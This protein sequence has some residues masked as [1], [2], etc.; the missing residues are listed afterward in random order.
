MS[1][2]ETREKL[3]LVSIDGLHPG[4]LDLDRRGQSGGAPDNWLMPNVREFCEHALRYPE[5]RT[6]LPAATDMNHLNAVAGTSLAQTGVIGVWAQPT[7]WD[8]RGRAVIQS[9]SLSLAR[10]DRGREVDTLFHA[11]KRRWPDSKTCLLSG[12]EW[13]AEMFRTRSGPPPVDLLV[14]GPSHPAYVPA[15]AKE[16]FP[17][18]SRSSTGDGWAAHSAAALARL[19][20]RGLAALRTAA[21]WRRDPASHL[22]TRLYAGER[23]LL[24]LQMESFPSHFPHDRWIVDATLEVLR[25]EDPGLIMSILALCDDA[26]HCVGSAWDPTEFG[27]D[28]ISR[29][30]PFVY[31][32]PSLEVIRDVDT[33]FGRLMHG[34]E[35]AGLR[36]RSTVILYSDH[37]STNHIHAD[38]FE[39]TDVMGVLR[40][41]RVLRGDEVYAF[42]VSSY[43]VLYWREQKERVAD[44]KAALEDHRA[45]NPET[46]EWECPWWV[47]DR[48]AMRDGRPGVCPPG[49]LYHRHFTRG[50]RGQTVI[51]PELILL[52]RNGWQIPVYN[53]HVANVGIKAPKWTPP[54]RV[55]KGGHGSLDTLPILAAVSA[56]GGRTGEQP[57]EITIGDLGV[58]A[59]ERFGLE[60]RSTTVGRSLCADLAAPPSD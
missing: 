1:Q 52:A 39:S 26:G 8:S 17:R 2:Q 16:G 27:S 59:A 22:L 28:G 49:E 47:L 11:W 51:W 15:P 53:G 41:A 30:N 29:R 50:E 56:P 31:R 32:E 20:G 37:G 36:D 34:L 45:L 40:R 13:V 3:I 46:G 54:F 57:G 25:R 12:K 9:S 33:Q 7:G 21:E 60:L 19:P 18:A 48:D 42:S 38:A 43:A 24:T 14:T 55:Y 4:Y 6:F 35:S 10:D 5:A 44:A 23:T 58:T